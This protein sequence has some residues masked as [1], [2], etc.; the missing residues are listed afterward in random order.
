MINKDKILG[1]ILLVSGTAIGAGMLALPVSTAHNGF[2]PSALSFFICWVFITLAALL[3]LEINLGFPGE[4]DLISM[5][6][7]TLG[8]PGKA[9]AW[10]AYLL[11]LY[12]LI[13]A[14]LTG[15][16]VWLVKMFQMW[17]INLPFQSSV[18]I[19]LILFGIIISYGM[20][21]VEYINR[22]LMLGLVVS[23]LLVIVFAIPSVDI[24]K[25]EVANYQGLSS[26]FSLIITSFGFSIILPSLTNYLQRDPRALKI[27]VIAGGLIP[28]GVYL[29]WEWVALGIIPLSGSE[30]LLNLAA[31]HNDGTGVAVAL[32]RIIGNPWI[33]HASR[34]FAIFA[35]LTSL[36]G[37]S[38]ALFHFLADGLK[39]KP[40]G[41][42]KLALL[43]LTFLPPWLFVLLF[44]AG[45][46]RILSFAGIFVAVLLGIMPAIMVW[47]Y[48]YAHKGLQSRS[49]YQVEG[50]KGVLLA[51]ILFFGYVTYLEVIRCLAYQ[52][53]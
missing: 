36:L 28:L 40:V 19:L 6:S 38:L 30:G 14:Y 35:I 22:Y 39:L 18:F 3:L 51:V 25:I 5:V 20:F 21:I 1:G 29:L 9:T 50:G 11:L 42:R 2:I 23:Y 10:V 46:G 17:H 26:S 47:R 24:N 12:S 49:V 4:K 16:S 33:T 48:R 8:V 13:A 44:P 32:E 27:V 37:V 34:W 45:F 53:I 31:Q 15:S 7:A 43:F 41:S 52:P